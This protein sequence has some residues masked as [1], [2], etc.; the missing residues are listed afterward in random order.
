MQTPWRT[1][2]DDLIKFSLTAG[3]GLVILSQGLTALQLKVFEK[4]VKAELDSMKS[5]MDSMERKMDSMER[6]M[7][8]MDAKLD[9]VLNKRWFGF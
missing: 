7:D 9:K 8:S 2:W 1:S 6:K 4:D 3:G 5:K